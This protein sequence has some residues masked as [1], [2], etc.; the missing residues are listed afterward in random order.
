MI[1]FGEPSERWL[2]GSS[3]A[4]GM[5]SYASDSGNGGGYLLFTKQ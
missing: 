3:P 1:A 2:I 4:F 5:T